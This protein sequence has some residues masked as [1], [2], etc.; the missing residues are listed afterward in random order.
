MV[1]EVWRDSVWARA[2]YDI[3]ADGTLVYIRGGDY[4][5][6]VPTWIGRDG[7]EEPLSIPRNI[8]GTFQLSPDRSRLAIQV[9]GAQDQIHIY[10]FARATLTRLTFEGPSWHPAW[11]HDGRDVIYAG[12]REGVVTLLRQQVDGSGEE[13]R[14]LTGEQRALIVAGFLD[15]YSVSPDGRHLLFTTWGNLEMR[16]D[17][18][19]LALDGES[20]PQPLLQTPDNEI[21]PMFSPDGNYIVYLSNKAGPSGIY[22]RPFPEVDRREWPISAKGGF[23]AR[24]SPAGNEI[25][26]RVGAMN[27]MSVPFELEPEL[28]P[29]SEHQILEM[30]FHDSAGFSFDLSADGNRILV[31][32]PAMSLKDDLP[33]IL[34]TDWF[35]EIEQ[36]TQ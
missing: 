15:P 6:T 36:A 17:I 16:A 27:L 12:L 28:T 25:L 9:S 4:A 31:N 13:V 1:P 26:Y 29:G 19:V 33:V 11:S 10:D 5:E 7:S 18:W 34:V 21:I 8:H 14:L 23:D 2:K 20:D 30:D 22:A 24:W 35:A 3:A 32:K